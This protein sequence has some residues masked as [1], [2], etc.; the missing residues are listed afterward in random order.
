MAQ[1]GTTA[2][3]YDGSPIPSCSN[4]EGYTFFYDLFGHWPSHCDERASTPTGMG[5]LRSD[6][7]RTEDPTAHPSPS[8][9]SYLYTHPATGDGARDY[10]KYS[11]TSSLTYTAAQERSLTWLNATFSI[12]SGKLDVVAHLGNDAWLDGQLNFGSGN[13]AIEDGA[14]IMRWYWSNDAANAIEF[15]T[16]KVDAPLLGSDA[17]GPSFDS[18]FPLL[19]GSSSFGGMSFIHAYRRGSRVYVMSD[20][21]VNYSTFRQSSVFSKALM[22]NNADELNFINGTYL[23]NDSYTDTRVWLG[24]YRSGSSWKRA[25]NNGSLPYASWVNG[26]APHHVDPNFFH[27]FWDVFLEK[28]I[29]QE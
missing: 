18:G 29:E 25:D 27:E 24:Q 4:P 9:T 7:T 2:N 5:S 12:L 15:P 28:S 22:L 1:H 14:S 19:N 13:G 6:L 23:P 3:D 11:P 8:N 16:G 17:M 21:Q 10:Y 26:Q 20:S